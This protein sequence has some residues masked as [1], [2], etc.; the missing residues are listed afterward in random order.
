LSPFGYNETV[1][2][3]YFPLKKEREVWR[4]WEVSTSITSNHNFPTL[5]QFSYFSAFCY[6]RSDYISDPI[7]PPG[8]TTLMEDQVP[9]NIS[10][11]TDDICKQIIICE[12]S[13][14]PFM[15]QK[16]ELVFYRKHNIP[17]PRRHPDI[18]HEDR[19]K[20][21]PGR[22]LHLRCCDKCGDEML[23][24]YEDLGKV[25]EVRELGWLGEVSLSIDSLLTPLTPSQ[26]SH[27]LIYCE[28]CYQQ[29]V[30]A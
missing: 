5:S 29:E 13:W 6:H 20:L 3:E 12:V 1:A 30:Y 25:G 27:P 7:I 9:S 8:I 26:S 24:V 22:T 18:R 21:R 14:R 10:T 17:L 23:S 11:V 28:K 16:A 4:V 15:I 2:M 19:M